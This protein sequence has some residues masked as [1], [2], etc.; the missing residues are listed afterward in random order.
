MNGLLRC[1]AVVMAAVLMMCC[2]GTSSE[3]HAQQCNVQQSQSNVSSAAAVQD[4]VRAVQL[5]QSLQARV[6]VPTATSAV[7]TAGAVPA[8]QPDLTRLLSALAAAQPRV[9]AP[10]ATATAT[11]GSVPAPTV[12]DSQLLALL[13]SNLSAAP[14]SNGCSSG[15]CSRSRAL[16][17]TRQGGG[18]LQAAVLRPRSR[19]VS[20]S[21]SLSIVR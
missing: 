11:A 12:S 5:Q 20:S 9:Q 13:S 8:A 3:C 17:V 10:Q 18:L 7:A 16:S 19:S 21:R 14:V 1:A 6:A 2:I 15:G 4:L